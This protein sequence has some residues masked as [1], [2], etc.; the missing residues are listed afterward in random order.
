VGGRSND[1]DGK[2]L[3]F[4]VVELERGPVAAMRTFATLGL[5]DHA[6]ALGDDG[7]TVRQEVVILGRAQFGSGNLPGILQQVGL[8]ALATHRAYLHGEV[9]RR[10]GPLFEDTLLEA[11]YVAM[12]VYFPDDFHVFT[13]AGA[14]R[15]VLAWLV[16]ITGRG[17]SV[18][19]R[20]RGAA[21]R[22]RSGPARLRPVVDR[23]RFARH[24]RVGGSAISA[25]GRGCGPRGRKRAAGTLD[26]ER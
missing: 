5:S 21:A 19:V 8:D 13:P 2:K 26:W 23:L 10:S 18:R 3:P 9:I 25:V 15:I 11:L 20:V 24:D 16:P 14:D 6:L 7:R 1:A 4:N 22:G 12:P 17:I